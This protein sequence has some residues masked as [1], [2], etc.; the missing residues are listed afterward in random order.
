MICMFD[1]SD[2][3]TMMLIRKEVFVFSFVYLC[4]CVG[5]CAHVHACVWGRCVHACVRDMDV[6][7]CVCVCVWGGGGVMLVLQKQTRPP[8]PEQ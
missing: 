6:C 2:Q 1:F 4:V 3:S 5:G 7:V 8:P